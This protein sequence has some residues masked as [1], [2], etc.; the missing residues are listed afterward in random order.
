MHTQATLISSQLF[1][2][3]SSAASSNTVSQVPALRLTASPGETVL[4]QG[5]SCECFIYIE[6]GLVKVEKIA[7]SGHEIMLYH[8]GPGQS[9]ELATSC[10][11]AGHRYPAIAQAEK[12]STI[13]LINK[14]EFFK[15]FLAN[16]GFR[17]F[18]FAD[19]DNATSHLLDLLED[20]V[21]IPLEQRIARFLYQQHLIRNPVATTH[22]QIA[23]ELG[24]AREVVS[25]LLKKFESNNWIQRSRGL[26]WI[27]NSTALKELADI[28][29]G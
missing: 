2:E 15:L 23:V 25:R 12:P 19:L 20:V 8:L 7:A 16:A 6:T 18:I 17:Q 22:Q 29:S 9:C 10:L 21:A 28:H 13:L 1:I 26:I 14:T 5:R 11:L 24:S 27:S 3:P 4:Q